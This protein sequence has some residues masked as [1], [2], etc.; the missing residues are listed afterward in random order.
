MR[1]KTL[2]LWSWFVS[3]LS[4]LVAMAG[5]LGWAQ[6]V[7]LRLRIDAERE[8]KQA[9]T[10]TTNDG[11]SYPVEDI[12][13]GFDAKLTSQ[14]RKTLSKLKL[15][16]VKIWHDPIEV[17]VPG[18]YESGGE[19]IQ[20]DQRRISVSSEP[21]ARYELETLTLEQLPSKRPVSLDLK[22]LMINRIQYQ[23]GED[24]PYKD[25]FLGAL[26]RVYDQAGNRIASISALHVPRGS[27][28]WDIVEKS[29]AAKSPWIPIWNSPPRPG[30]EPSWSV[31]RTLV[32]AAAPKAISPPV[33]LKDLRLDL[34]LNNETTIPSARSW[35]QLDEESGLNVIVEEAPARYTGELS[36]QS[37]EVLNDARV[38]FAMLWHDP[39]MVYE[40]GIY[41]DA[42]GQ[43][44]RLEQEQ[45][46]VNWTAPHIQFLTQMSDITDLKF[47]SRVKFEPEPIQL[48]R[49]A[50]KK[51]LSKNPR[52]DRLIGV[53]VRV[54]D[55]QGTVVAEHTEIQHSDFRKASLNWTAI[56][57]ARNR[58][59]SWIPFWDRPPAPDSPRSEL[60][61]PYS[62]PMQ[63]VDYFSPTAPTR[64]GEWRMFTESQSGKTIEAR[65]LSFNRKSQLAEIE[66]KDGRKF[67]LPMSRF[68]VDDQLYVRNWLAERAGS[69]MRPSLK[70]EVSASV[71]IGNPARS[72]TWW[73]RDHR[74]YEIEE[75]PVNFS[76]NWAS[77]EDSLRT[78]IRFQ[79]AT[80]WYDTV[81]L[82]PPGKYRDANGRETE[83]G[84]SQTSIDRGRRIARFHLQDLPL[85]RLAPGDSESFQTDNLIM[86]RI[87][88]PQSGDNPF[89]DKPLGLLARI[90]N[91]KGE[92]LLEQ[93]VINSPRKSFSWKEIDQAH[94]NGVN[95]IGAW[96]VPPLASDPPP[97]GEIRPPYTL[98]QPTRSTQLPFNPEPGDLPLQGYFVDAVSTPDSKTWNYYDRDRDRGRV[99]VEQFTAR[100][101]GTVTYSGKQALQNV[102]VQAAML[103]FDPIV[104]IAPNTNYLQANGEEY[105]GERTG[106]GI[107]ADWELDRAVFQFQSL[108]L[109]ELS[110]AQRVIIKFEDV[111]FQR[112]RS[113]LP[114][115]KNPD[116]DRL[117]GVIYRV[118]DADGKTLGEGAQFRDLKDHKASYTWPAID[119][120]R[121]HGF[122]WINA[123][124]VPPP[125]DQPPSDKETPFSPVRS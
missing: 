77:Q 84:T 85:E 95:W 68:S 119:R 108:K 58:K 63:E 8:V 38:E 93:T 11:R 41:R 6:E 17:I 56:D 35:E 59:M 15:E 34:K 109:P 23:V 110:P 48:Q 113:K 101:S 55:R 125:P 114:S 42:Q 13:L 30:T 49:Y 92:T 98:V 9:W 83:I 51:A 73:T 103:W 117:L 19:E 94:E 43:D 39:I 111:L 81:V 116:T 82:Y 67:E 10:W 118:V 52:R 14:E 104:A 44:V 36:Y 87:V 100:N 7:N 122:I 47:G 57:F 21:R 24:H 76:G 96:D 2:P 12:E 31:P 106:G 29:V 16:I 33:D 78:G 20:I 5:G 71:E 65:I 99:V 25:Q 112:Y 3:F 26:M 75:F 50:S 32:H 70:A 97:E 120:A 91:A 86:Q 66:M 40:P 74:A 53:L 121:T 22:P 90:Q 105:R 123:W 45:R 88:Y 61:T 102:E 37:R 18:V 72:W 115:S 124:D 89:E 1:P 27:F 54:F 107:R 79:I 64:G 4:G 69:T 46:F 60:T 62:V 28:R 80:L